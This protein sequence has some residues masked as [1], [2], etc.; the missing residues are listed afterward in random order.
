M[1]GYLLL[2]PEG[3]SWTVTR[4]PRPWKPP[5]HNRPPVIRIGVPGY[6]NRWHVY[7]DRESAV[8]DLKVVRDDPLGRGARLHRVE[9]DVGEPEEA[10]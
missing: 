9:L 6:G 3:V 1:T 10:A 2:D 5:N 4:T 8:S 7:R